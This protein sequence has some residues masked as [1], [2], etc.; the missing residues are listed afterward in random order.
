M[1]MHGRSEEYQEH[2]RPNYIYFKHVCSRSSALSTA[3]AHVTFFGVPKE[4][5]KWVQVC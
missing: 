1:D 5:N 2:Y 4:Q 3:E